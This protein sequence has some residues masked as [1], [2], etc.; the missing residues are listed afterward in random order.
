MSFPVVLLEIVGSTQE[1]LKLQWFVDHGQVAVL[2]DRPVSLRSVTVKLNQDIVWV[3]KIDRLTDA[4]ISHDWC[5][6]SANVFQILIDPPY[7][8]NET[9]LIRV[10]ERDMMEAS[11]LVWC[12]W[13]S[14][15]GQRVQCDVMV[16]ATK[17]EKGAP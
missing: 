14:F 6:L 4:M 15:A 9:F 12:R 13:A 10:E 2:I 8:S 16:I 1:L 11:T 3:A 5:I 7:C 17:P